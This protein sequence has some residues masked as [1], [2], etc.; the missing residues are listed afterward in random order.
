MLQASSPALQEARHGLLDHGKLKHS[1]SGCR[2]PRPRSGSAVY[3]AQ[4]TAVFSI[5]FVLGFAFSQVK[6]AQTWEHDGLGL[7][8]G[9]IQTEFYLNMTFAQRPTPEGESAWGDLHAILVS[10]YSALEAADL[11]YNITPPDD[12]LN[13]TGTR[14][15]PSHI[16]HCFDYL[17]QTIMCAADTNLEVLDKETHT[18][19]GW[20]QPRICRDYERVFSWAEKWANSSDTGLI[21]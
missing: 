4:I 18:T 8:P 6:S 15:A 3:L 16:R 2:E 17:R 20:G 7:P 11:Q 13:R 10:Y 5:A 1:N 14:M 12:F 19:S 21:T 9:K